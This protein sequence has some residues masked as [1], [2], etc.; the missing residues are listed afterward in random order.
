M[1]PHLDTEKVSRIPSLCGI[2]VMSQSPLGLSHMTAFSSASRGSRAWRR[3]A[4]HGGP[5]SGNLPQDQHSPTQAGGVG[6]E[7]RVQRGIGNHLPA[8]FSR[9]LSNAAQCM[10]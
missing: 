8:V 6:V 1:R 2:C 3:F 4:S 10:N 9:T 5:H 7:V